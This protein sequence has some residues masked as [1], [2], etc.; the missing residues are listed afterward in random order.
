MAADSQVQ[1]GG[2]NARVNRYC[3]ATT[4]GGVE[5]LEVETLPH[6]AGPAAVQVTNPDGL[7][8]SVLGGFHYLNELQ[9][10]AVTP[11]VVRVAQTGVDD[12][13]QILGYGFGRDITLKAYP[14]ASE[15]AVV[16]HMGEGLTLYS[17]ER[18]DWQVSDFGEQYRGF[19]DIEL[20]DAQGR[21]AILPSALFMGRLV[22]NRAI[23]TRSP[24]RKTSWRRNWIGWI[25]GYRASCLVMR[26]CCLRAR[27]LIWPRMPP[28]G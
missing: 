10:S 24:F 22:V 8:V 9:I 17:P 16:T 25:K 5:Q 13:V 7:S 1:I 14:S 23:E 2:Q 28:L 3:P 21:R 15:L 11:A 18:L 6:Y 19:V 4:A 27:S 20:S 12:T 26:R